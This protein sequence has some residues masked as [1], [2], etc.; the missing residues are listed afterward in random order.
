MLKNN[1]SALLLLL[2]LALQIY[3]C[4]QLNA[5]K[6]QLTDLQYILL[7]T[8]ARIDNIEDAVQAEKVPHNPLD[9]IIKQLNEEGQNKKD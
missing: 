6:E 5:N 8:G 9:D 3:I 7:V 2:I 1:L 4:I